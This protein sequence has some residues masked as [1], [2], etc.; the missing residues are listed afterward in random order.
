MY[1]A[2]P[3]C[4]YVRQ[5]GEVR[6]DPTGSTHCLDCGSPLVETESTK[7]SGQ[8][9]AESFELAPRITFVPVMTLLNAELE[10]FVQSLLQWPGISFYVKG[11]RVQDLFGVGRFGLGFNLVTGPPVLFVE[12]SRAEEASALLTLLEEPTRDDI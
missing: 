11:K 10:T 7:G 5:T 3:D 12:P 8:P 9:F 2:N 4:P 1:C 6:E